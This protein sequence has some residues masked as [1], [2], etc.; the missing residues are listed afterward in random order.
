[1]KHTHETAHLAFPIEVYAIFRNSAKE[2]GLSIREYF[3]TI[4]NYGVFFH[5]LT[6]LETTKILIQTE[7][8]MFYFTPEML[9][10]HPILTAKKK[11]V[12]QPPC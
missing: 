6:R 12:E 4:L 3:T 7:N 10:Q 2:A 11:P 8:N 5:A 1:V 9:K